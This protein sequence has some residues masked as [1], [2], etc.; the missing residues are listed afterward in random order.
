MDVD[1]LPVGEYAFPGPLRDQLVAAILEGRKTS[2]TSL[3]EDYQRDG[4]P[5]PVAGGREAVVDSD[6]TRVCVTENVGVTICALG[7][8]D[9]AHAVAEGEGFTSVAAWRAAHERFWHSAEYRSAIRDDAFTVHDGT[10]VV[11]VTFRVIW[12]HRTH[13][14]PLS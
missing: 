14:H 3:L 4:E 6:G 1:A 5:V 7:E 9:L 8:V 10:P 2:T 11:C 13:G 12:D